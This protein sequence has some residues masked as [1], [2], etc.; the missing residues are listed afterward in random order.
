MLIP[1]AIFTSTYL[2]D[3]QLIPLHTFSILKYL[4]YPRCAPTA[5]AHH[6]IM[7]PKLPTA[8][9]G[10]NFPQ[11]KRPR[12]ATTIVFWSH[13]PASALSV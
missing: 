10:S 2:Y 6:D 13:E 7:E 9:K 1:K 5:P 3:L 11:G 4:L 8:Q 12:N